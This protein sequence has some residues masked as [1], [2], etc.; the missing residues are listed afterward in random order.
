[1]ATLFPAAGYILIGLILMF[2][3]PLTKKVVQENSAKLAAMR[4]GK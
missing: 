3:Y 2:A 4:E 1:M